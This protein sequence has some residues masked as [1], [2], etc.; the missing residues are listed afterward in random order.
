[1]IWKS[2]WPIALILFAPDAAGAGE[3]WREQSERVVRGHAGLLVENARGQTEVR[4]GSADQIRIV[5]LK[6]ARGADRDQARRLAAETRVETGAEGS[7]YVVRVR[8][9][10]RTMR[11]NFWDS[12]HGASSPRIEVRFAIEVPDRVAVRLRSASGDLVSEQVGGVQT[13]RSTSGDVTVRQPRGPVEAVSTSGDV[14]ASELNAARLR[15]V[16]GDVNVEGAAGPLAIFTT[17]G[18]VGIR[19]AADSLR[20]ETVSGDIS[21]DAAPLGL[22]LETVSG[23]VEVERAAGRIR[24]AS[25]SGDLEVGLNAP[26]RRA[27]LTTSSGDVVARIAPAVGC[28]L[29]MRTSSG[30][31]ETETPV[32][33][34]TISRQAVRAVVGDGSAPVS[35]RSSSGNITVTG[36]TR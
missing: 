10:R 35:I 16:S 34:R 3:V 12:I 7:W 20:V 29:E 28:T 5:A 15:T 18:G 19:R 11:V 26:L 8:Y 30:A 36:G 31:I 14:W 21:V 2:L 25:A 4:R 24:V 6:V 17:S 33:T 22:D 13:L 32:L 27:E 23:G 1:V 9:P